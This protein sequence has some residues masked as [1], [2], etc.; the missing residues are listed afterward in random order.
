MKEGDALHIRIEGDKL[1]VEKA[2]KRSSRIYCESCARAM[3]M[4]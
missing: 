1:I 4:I 2:K 3:K